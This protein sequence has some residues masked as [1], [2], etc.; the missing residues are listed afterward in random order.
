MVIKLTMLKLLLSK[1]R[2]LHYLEIAEPAQVLRLHIVA[3]GN[4][5][6]STAMNGPVDILLC[7]VGDGP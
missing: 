2:L 5:N 3:S 1:V 7:M 4:R 6:R